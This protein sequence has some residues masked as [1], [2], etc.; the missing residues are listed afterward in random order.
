MRALTTVPSTTLPLTSLLALS[1][2][3]PNAV[4]ADQTPT[5]S[6]IH[7]SGQASVRVEPD[8]A[9]IRL[10]VETQ[11]DTAAEAQLETSR[12]V[13]AIL[14]GLGELGVP[15]SEIQTASLNVRPIY[16]QQRSTGGEPVTPKVIGYRAGNTVS[17]SITDLTQVGPAIDAAIEAGANRVLGLSFDL[18]E[19][20]EAQQQALAAAVERAAAKAET[21]AKTLGRR[22]GRVIEVHEGGVSVR[23]TAVSHMR[24]EMAFDE[25]TPVASGKVGVSASVTIRYALAD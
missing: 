19:D 4:S 14:A 20:A 22:L 21:I 18:R 5:E 2:L 16:S 12:V 8:H 13:Q 3:L 7:V 25:A 6:Q 9:L 11:R 17:A 1:L 23:P 15:E 24:A 10:G